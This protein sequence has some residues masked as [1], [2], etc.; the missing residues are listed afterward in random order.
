MNKLTSDNVC[1]L[2]KNYNDILIISISIVYGSMRQGID[3]I[4]I[5]ATRNAP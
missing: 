1:M 2:D 3:G 5:Q 4:K